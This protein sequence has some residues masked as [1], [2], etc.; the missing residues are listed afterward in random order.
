[1]IG[2]VRGWHSHVSCLCVQ[3]SVV[4]L[5]ISSYSI[6]LMADQRIWELAWP[7]DLEFHWRR[8][9]CSKLVLVLLQA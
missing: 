4:P 5:L 7:R 9:T 8:R 2:V 6:Q 3:Y 1:M